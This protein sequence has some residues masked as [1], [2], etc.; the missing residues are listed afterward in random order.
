MTELWAGLGG[1]AIGQL[2][3]VQLVE[4]N[5]G[6][7]PLLGRVLAGIRRFSTTSSSGVPVIGEG[8]YACH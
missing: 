4:Q 1:A 2:L 3:L 7:G 8:G 6:C 5:H